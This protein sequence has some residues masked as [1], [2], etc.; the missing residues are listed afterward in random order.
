MCPTY[1][2][3]SWV[4]S[5]P[6]PSLQ[7][8][9]KSILDGS[10]L[11]CKLQRSDYQLWGL[12]QSTCS[13]NLLYLS[14]SIWGITL[15]KESKHGLRLFRTSNLLLSPALLLTPNQNSWWTEQHISLRKD[16]VATPI[17]SSQVVKHGSESKAAPQDERAA[18]AT[19]PAVPGSRQGRP[20]HVA[21]LPCRHTSQQNLEKSESLALAGSTEHP[22]PRECLR[23]LIFSRVALV[24]SCSHGPVA[25]STAES[26]R[27]GAR[28]C[29][30]QGP[31]STEPLCFLPF[32]QI[33][34]TALFRLCMTV[35]FNT[36]HKLNVCL[37][38]ANWQ[39]RFLFTSWK[40]KP[41]KT[42][43]NQIPRKFSMELNYAEI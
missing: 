28:G 7:A 26:A 24:S 1:P 38:T 4:P 8:Y 10:S 27:L 34:N 29:Q 14:Q 41:P 39:K 9:R 36:P 17:L 40:R 18:H 6:F 33:L 37:P 11:S 3:K 25:L 22:E 30:E 13:S 5:W 2:A 31:R 16:S 20:W 42:P 35:F 23:A 12:K 32:W 15:G 19:E 21:L 43:Q